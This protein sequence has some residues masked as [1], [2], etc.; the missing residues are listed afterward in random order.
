MWVYIPNIYYFHSLTDHLLFFCAVVDCGSPP[1]LANG[2]SD[3]PLTIFG[4]IATYIC[5]DGY[6]FTSESD[7]PRQRECLSSGDWSEAT[8]ECEQGMR[9]Q[10]LRLL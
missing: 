8:F 6:Q 3:S 5:N 10:H 7:S 4:E 1:M 2:G 9:L